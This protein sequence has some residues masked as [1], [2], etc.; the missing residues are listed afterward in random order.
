MA[1][2]EALSFQRPGSPQGDSK[3]TDFAKLGTQQ[4]I[5]LWNL[6]HIVHW[7]S[8]CDKWT[9]NFSFEF[10]SMNI[11]PASAEMCCNFNCPTKTQLRQP[12][13]HRSCPWCHS[14]PCEALKYL[15][16]YCFTIRSKRSDSISHLN[17]P[18]HLD[19]LWSRHSQGQTVNC[20]E[21][22]RVAKDLRNLE[23]EFPLGMWGDFHTVQWKKSWTTWNA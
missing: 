23:S 10:L 12:R 5:I 1:F 8:K 16:R 17:V 22:L 19:E 6:Y 13:H 18:Q 2:V 11:N 3:G 9:L 4:R 20:R 7:R 21:I 15:K 14:T